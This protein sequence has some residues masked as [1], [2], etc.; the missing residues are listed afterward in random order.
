MA[1]G[2]RVVPFANAQN[3]SAAVLSGSH[4]RQYFP[5][6]QHRAI[7]VLCRQMYLSVYTRRGK[8]EDG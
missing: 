2:S 5:T 8:P 6:A 3:L 4:S 1:V 7:C